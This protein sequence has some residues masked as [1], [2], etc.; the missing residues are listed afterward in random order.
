V[1]YNKSYIEQLKKVLL[2]RCLTMSVVESVTG[3]HIQAA[4]SGADQASEFFHGGMIAYNLGQKVK[5]LKVD[6]ICAEKCNCV[7]K[8][9]SV[10]MAFGIAE[11][12]SSDVGI[13][14]TGYATPLPEKGVNK[15]YAWMAVVCNH[16]LIGEYRLDSPAESS[17]VAQIDY[18]N[19]TIEKTWN[20]LKQA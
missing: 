4:L 12:F 9:I 7:S 18:T 8:E 17:F 3:G 15:I 6:P 13:A 5:H 10:A 1:I 2:K 16:K 14:I 11:L 20:L 19:M